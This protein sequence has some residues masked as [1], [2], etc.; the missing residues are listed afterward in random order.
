MIEHVAT[1]DAGIDDIVISL[2]EIPLFETLDKDTLRRL[3]QHFERLEVHAGTLVIKEGDPGDSLYIVHSGLLEV[4]RGDPQRRIRLLRA[5][6]PFGEV[7]LLTGKERVADVRAVR[8]AELWRLPREAFAELLATDPQ[9]A[10]AMVRALTELIVES[11]APATEHEPTPRVFALLP[12][13]PGS[14]TELILDGFTAS[15]G[16]VRICREHDA[17]APEGWGRIVESHEQSGQPVVLVASPERS[18]WFA[19]CMREADRALALADANT[20]FEPL[21]D[22]VRPDLLLFGQPA[23]GSVRRAVGALSAR[24]HHRVGGNE[25]GAVA[26]ALRRVAGRSTGLV[27]SGGGARG[28]AHVGVYQALTEAGVVVDR[29][30]GT[31]MGSLVGAL[32]ASGAGP[33]DLRSVLH[34]ELVLRRPYGDFGVPRTSLIRAQRGRVMLDRLFRETAIED[35]PLDFFCISADLV[36]AEAVVHRQGQVTTAVAASMSLP[37]IAPPVTDGDRL[38]VDGGVLD[39]LPIEAMTSRREGPVIAV[40]VMARGLPRNRRA[41]ANGQPKLPNILETLARSVALASRGRAEQQRTFATMVITPE[42]A[43]VGL[44]EFKRIDAI[45]DAGRRAAEEA[46]AQSPPAGLVV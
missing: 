7:A 19:F 23:P 42:L 36:S 15:F 1:T 4:L 46:L 45:V 30:G 39:N 20:A 22:H 18:A 27:L 41:A 31:S 17:G 26:R 24:A 35:L 14:D 3:A 5:G 2:A 21:P 38:L 11:R 29:V 44:F 8:D 12:L 40:D 37:G 34:G 10:G 16:D 6:T 32:I 9:F 28:L 13:H 43:D 33:R 25:R